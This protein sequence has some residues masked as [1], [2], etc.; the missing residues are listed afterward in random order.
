MR[1]PTFRERAREEIVEEGLVGMHMY[2]PT[3]VRV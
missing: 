3:R 2:F 1:Y